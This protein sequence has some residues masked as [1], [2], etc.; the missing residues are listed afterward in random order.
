M[1]LTVKG[2]KR[3]RDRHGRERIY[4]RKSGTPIDA[5]LSAAEIAAEVARLDK[6]HAPA[7]AKVG[8]MGAMLAS[9]RAS[10]RFTGLA[11]RT[12]ADYHRAMDWLKPIGD[13]P[14]T[15]LTPGFVAKLRD[16]AFRQKRGGFANHM[17]AML[18]SAC[19]HGKEY[20]LLD[21]NPCLGLDKA[22]IPKERRQPNRPW[23]PAERANVIAAAPDHLKVVLALARFFGIRRG[24]IVRL[25]RMA[26]RDGHLSW[27][28]SKTGRDMKI[29]V[30][31]E[32]KG[33]L[34]AYLASV[35]VSDI[36]VTMLCVNSRGQPWTEAGL[37]ASL[38][39][40]FRQC[41]RRGIGGEGLTI[42]GLR[43]TVA[44][45]LKEL[46]FDR[47]WRKH[48]L[49]HDTDATADHY[50]SSAD[51]SG[52]LIDMANVLQGGTKRKRKLS[53][54]SARSV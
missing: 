28:T 1:R 53:N 20:D 8:T 32:A 47:E 38:Q 41:V 18:S 10:P 21:A 40:F 23:S 9:Y 35:P 33:I 4:H 46:G 15:L 2:L 3:Y 16:E 31:G 44:A 54:Q 24:D 30:V 37:S 25:P 7:K 14:L 42:H 13:T 5:G 36:P 17:L 22:R 43:H 52:T 26:Y 11:A 48:Y 19:K 12:Q 50:A 39:K 29:P 49:G 27:R 34:E 51:V 6:L 45:E